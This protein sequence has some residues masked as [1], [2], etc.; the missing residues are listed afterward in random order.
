MSLAASSCLLVDA[1]KT[2]TTLSIVEGYLI[3][4]HPSK[5]HFSR[6]I[7]SL[8]CCSSKICMKGVCWENY[9]W[10]L[11]QKSCSFLLIINVNIYRWGGTLMMTRCG[12]AWL[13]NF[14]HFLLLPRWCKYFSLSMLAINL[15]EER[16][17]HEEEERLVT[18]EESS[19]TLC[20]YFSLFFKWHSPSSVYFSSSRSMVMIIELCVLD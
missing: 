8:A 7:F 19:V 2:T 6:V 14:S 10:C 5:C 4:Y 11:R 17:E 16:Q 1:R 15:H 20:W 12:G 18:R 9:G 3:L 13:G